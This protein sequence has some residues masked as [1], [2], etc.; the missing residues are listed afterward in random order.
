[1]ITGIIQPNAGT[2]EVCGIAVNPDDIQSK[3]KIGYLA[4]ANPLYWD[5]Y[6]R[7]YL[8]FIGGV[9]QI[10]DKKNRIEQIIHQ[11]GLTPESH[12][13]I[14]QLSK[15][16]KQRTGFAAA[17]LHDPEVLILD[18]PTSGLDPNQIS[19]IRELIK[20]LGKQKTILF[21]THI[22]QEVEALCQR[23]IIINKGLIVAN[24]RLDSLKSMEKGKQRLMVS[25]KETVNLEALKS[26]LMTEEISETSDSIFIFITS[27]ADTLRK[28]L[29]SHSVEK[30]LT[31]MNM[32]SEDA[33]LEHIFKS[34]TQREQISQD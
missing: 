17:L 15:G 16:Y 5:M 26:G 11:V 25:F 20:N 24:D 29:M 14:G 3:R 7:E 31:I 19:E 8:D 4:E 23:V 30:G 6:V 22:L 18:E 10:A 13:K 12:K 1:M 28:K 2:I 32:Q 27:D 34:L 9:H 33:P 21:S